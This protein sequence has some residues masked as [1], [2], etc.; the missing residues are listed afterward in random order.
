MVHCPV[1]NVDW[2]LIGQTNCVK[3]VREP[4]LWNEHGKVLL[5]VEWLWGL[6]WNLISGSRCI[7]NILY[8]NVISVFFPKHKGQI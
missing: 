7:F 1:Y 5:K 6:S 3:A 4:V 8:P 2:S